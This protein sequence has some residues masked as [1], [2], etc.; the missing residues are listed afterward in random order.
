M[1]G[2]YGLL[3]LVLGF[4]ATAAQADEPQRVKTAAE[5]VT[6][7]IDGAQITRSKQIDL[8]A[9]KTVLHFTGLS[10]L[11]DAKSLQVRAKGPLTITS[12]NHSFDFAD[13]LDRSA[14][15]KEIIQKI[16][17]NVN[18]QL[19]I[20]AEL[21]S[22]D[23]E[24]AL[25][26][27]NC[28]VAHRQVSTPLAAIKEL[29]DY[30][31]KKLGE[32]SQRKLLLERQQKTL[33]SLEQRMRLELEQIGGQQV[34]PTSIVEVNIESAAP[35]KGIFTLTYYV[36]NAQWYPSYDVRSEGLTEPIQL[37]YKAN[38]AQNTG[39]EWRNV[40][41]TLSSSNPV[42]SN[43]S[44]KLQPYWLG[45]NIAA[46][47]YDTPVVNN[48]VSGV[49]MDK[50]RYALAGVS[51]RVSNTTIATTTDVNGRYSLTVPEGKQTIEF[52]LIGYIPQT[53][54]I[55][56]SNLN[57]TLNESNTTNDDVVVVGY[58]PVRRAAFTGSVSV[59]SSGRR[60]SKRDVAQDESIPMDVQQEQTSLGYEYQIQQ[61]YTIPSDNKVV[62]AE[63][64]RYIIP[65]TYHYQSSPKITP[66]VFL[67]AEATDWEKLNLLAAE[68][69]V[70][71][72][73]TF[74]GKSILSPTQAADTLNFSLGRDRRILIERTKEKDYTSKK[75]MGS[76]R[77]Q[78]VGWKLTIRNTRAEP[79]SLVLYDQI[80]VSRNSQII[81]TP[82]ELSQGVLDPEN[83]IVTWKLDLR[84]TEQR[85]LILRYTVKYPKG[86][87]LTVE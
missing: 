63:I 79:V 5:E 82:E 17:R 27:G 24:L 30:Y 37:S 42:T 77:T 83:G 68:A 1:K 81:V 36:T 47:R 85:E 75:F 10:P 2:L 26:K 13:S 38:I 73:N 4:A 41:L 9:G 19:K 62:A 67:I 35:C 86:Q 48:T 64:G 61:P 60:G 28:S 43:I 7:F 71:F 59:V 8:P 53:H 39:E 72:E 50:D 22:I 33:I 65:T 12:V 15:R 74:I 32:Y 84:P 29:N 34:T 44:P 3:V 54:R 25:L 52:N 66:D 58:A 87:S 55:S 70:F 11:M 40:R 18:T 20:V 80:P 56:S 51:V 57:I 46:P 6:V 69:N 45:F 49:V 31:S 16:N 23:S 78:T 14:S 76:N 21:N